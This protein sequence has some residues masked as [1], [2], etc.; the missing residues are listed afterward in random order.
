MQV[1]LR[2]QDFYDLTW[3]YLDKAHTQGVI[4]VEMFFDPQGHTARGV[5]FEVVIGGI[6]R[7]QDDARQRLGLSSHLI[8][9]F[10]RHLDQADAQATLDAALPHRE[11]IIGV[12]LDSSEVGHPPS[13]FAAVFARARAEGFRLVAHAGE[14]GPASYVWEALEILKVDRIDHGNR[15][16]DDERLVERLV[17][18]Q[19]V[20]TVCPLSN[21]RLGVVPSIDAHP[22]RRMLDAG[23]KV[24]VNSDDPAYFGGYVNENLIAVQRALDLPREAIVALLR[25]SFAGAFLLPDEKDRLLRRLSAC[26]EA[27]D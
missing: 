23:L 12:G 9:C 14:E 6:R 21:V 22:L 3:A 26:S 17:A 19:T 7:A 1:L 11:W 25:N 4:H 20:L 2:E 24:T 15:A 27:A 10:L 16:L 5:P 18:A 8:M 13:K